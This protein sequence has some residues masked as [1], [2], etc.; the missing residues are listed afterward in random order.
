MHLDNRP[1]T[2]PGLQPERTTLSWTRTVVSLMIVSA[3]LL[4]WSPAFPTMIYV[5][6]AVMAGVAVTIY[7]TQRRRYARAGLGI[8][9]EQIHPSVGSVFLLTGAMILFG[10]AGLALLIRELPGL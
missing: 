4:R 2:D 5:V 6:I 9:Q 7:F 3:V 8:A 10:A 1:H